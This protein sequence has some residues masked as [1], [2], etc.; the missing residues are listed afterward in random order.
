MSKLD[1]ESNES[2]RKKESS[3]DGFKETSIEEKNSVF[4]LIVP[5]LFISII[6]FPP[7]FFLV[8]GVVAVLV[9]RKRTSIAESIDKKVQEIKTA[10]RIKVHQG[11]KIIKSI[12]KKIAM[13]SLLIAPFVLAIGY[14]ANEKHQ[15]CMKEPKCKKEWERSE[16][17]RKQERKIAEQERKEKQCMKDPVCKSQR[18]RMKC[19]Q[20]PKCKTK[21]MLSD[22]EISCIRGI[23]KKAKYDYKWG[24]LNKFPTHG[25][26]TQKGAGAYLMAGDKIEFKNGLGLYVRYSYECIYIP[27][28]GI[29]T[30]VW[31]GRLDPNR[32]WQSQ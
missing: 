5:A 1:N 18:D 22:I 20:D 19:M 4:S 3:K 28:E 10:T 11:A 30:T 12:I 9:W 14:Y 26:Y 8:L 32:Y 24:W 21:S 2:P 23:E 29:K 27:G 13:I 16:K 31:P 17:K 6:F 7:L 15:Q 25:H